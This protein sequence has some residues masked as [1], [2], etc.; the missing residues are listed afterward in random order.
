MKRDDHP[1]V[2]TQWRGRANDWIAARV[3]FCAC[4]VCGAPAMGPERIK[5][6]CDGCWEVTARL[7][8]FLRDGGDKAA[9]ILRIALERAGK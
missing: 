8:G 9:A 5:P 1:W 6:Q 2:G 3:E 7:D 4:A